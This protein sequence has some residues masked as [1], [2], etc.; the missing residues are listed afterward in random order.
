MHK[1][2]GCCQGESLQVVIVDGI[3]WVGKGKREFSGL[4]ELRWVCSE[5]KAKLVYCGCN[6]CG[7]DG[8]F[9][10]LIGFKE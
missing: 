5:V 9:Q 2:K 1:M 10:D 4:Y 7:L 8:R 3:F 6:E